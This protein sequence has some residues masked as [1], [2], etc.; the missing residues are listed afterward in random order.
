[1]LVLL[2][3][4]MVVLRWPWWGR[5]WQRA[6]GVEADGGAGVSAGGPAAGLSGAVVAADGGR[7][8]RWLLALLVVPVSS[9][10]DRSAAPCRTY[11]A[12]GHGTAARR[13]RPV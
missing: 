7:W 2:S 5:W 10:G 12:A 13:R 9:A 1:M 3:T 4:T 11:S 6:A 8:C